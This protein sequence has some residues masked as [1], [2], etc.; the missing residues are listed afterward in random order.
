MPT[1]PKKPA[2]DK[3]ADNR[4]GVKAAVALAAQITKTVN[5][6]RRTTLGVWVHYFY[7]TP[8][9][10]EPIAVSLHAKELEARTAAMDAVVPGKVVFVPWDGS[11]AEA[12]G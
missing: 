2:E 11:I 1:T 12:L 8:E 5:G 9:H 6:D 3:G 7:L 10:L 4:D